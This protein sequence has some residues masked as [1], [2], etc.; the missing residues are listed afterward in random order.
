MSSLVF[1]ERLPLST[2]LDHASATC[3]AMVL[4]FGAVTQRFILAAKAFR[5]FW[6][7]ELI[8]A[9]ASSSAMAPQMLPRSRGRVSIAIRDCQTPALRFETREWEV[10]RFGTCADNGA[11]RAPQELGGP[12]PRSFQGPCSSCFEVLKRCVRWLG[13]GRRSIRLNFGSLFGMGEAI[14]RA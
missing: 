10:G 2:A 4:V 7:I 13:V 1:S 5:S 11:E 12:M 8:C 14:A 9:S 6:P 3:G